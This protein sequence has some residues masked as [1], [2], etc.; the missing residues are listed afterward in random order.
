M[1]FHEVKDAHNVEI[2]LQTISE[3][4]NIFKKKKKQPPISGATLP[5]LG[6]SQESHQLSVSVSP[7]VFLEDL[8]GRSHFYLKCREDIV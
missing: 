7:R 3:Y 6:L 1:R 4:L 5:P 8:G 2:S